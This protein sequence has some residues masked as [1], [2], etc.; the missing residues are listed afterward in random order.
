MTRRGLAVLCSVVLCAL[1]A[2]GCAPQD[3]TKTA[4][5]LD[6][7]GSLRFPVDGVEHE[8]NFRELAWPAPGAHLLD[9]KSASD[10]LR[11]SRLE[12]D[13]AVPVPGAT[14]TVRS[15][16]VTHVD[17]DIAWRRDDH[18]RRHH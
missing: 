11:L 17:F 8:L 10:S 13:R 15:F 16:D 2:H 7:T 5:V 9:G 12:G 18:D 14:L 6:P 4:A 3:V 1:P